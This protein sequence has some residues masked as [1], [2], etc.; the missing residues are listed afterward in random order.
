M[1]ETHHSLFARENATRRRRT[2][3]RRPRLRQPRNVAAGSQRCH[4]TKASTCPQISTEDATK[5]L[6]NS[7]VKILRIL[8]YRSD[9]ILSVEF[10]LFLRLISIPVERF[11]T[12]TKERSRPAYQ[13]LPR[14]RCFLVALLCSCYDLVSCIGLKFVLKAVRTGKLQTV[15]I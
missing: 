6:Q 3:R 12:T 11:R 13:R 1:A 5:L 9:L 2:Q 14:N 15:Y 10:K 4:P 8:A 7:E